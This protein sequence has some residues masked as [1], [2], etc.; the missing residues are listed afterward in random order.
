MVLDHDVHWEARTLA[1]YLL[2]CRS[3]LYYYGCCF[4]YGRL[5][6]DRNAGIQ[7]TVCRIVPH[8]LQMR[9]ID[10]VIS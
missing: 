8:D 7:R 10:E 6:P 1:G 3:Q 2:S 5:P 4:G 9:E